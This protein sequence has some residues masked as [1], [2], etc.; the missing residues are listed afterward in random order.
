MTNGIVVWKRDVF[1]RSVRVKKV[2]NLRNGALRTDKEI[3]ETSFEFLVKLWIFQASN[4]TCHSCKIL[5]I[6]S[7]IFSN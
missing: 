6:F 5:N 2:P 1:L 7:K 4:Y 3:G